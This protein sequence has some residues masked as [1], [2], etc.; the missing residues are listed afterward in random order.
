MG[1]SD[2]ILKGEH[3]RII[4]AKFHLICFSDF[5]GVDLN[6][7]VYN[8]RLVPSDGKGYMAFCQVTNKLTASGKQNDLVV[9]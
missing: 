3:P 1:L 7:K 2:L 8:G 4:Q 6:V 5:R 9:N